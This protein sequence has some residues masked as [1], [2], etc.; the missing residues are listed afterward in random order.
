MWGRSW[1]DP[2]RGCREQLIVWDC[3]R[4]SQITLEWSEVLKD[5]DVVGAA[6]IRLL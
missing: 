6:V 1:H 4:N 2:R 5:L 3:Y